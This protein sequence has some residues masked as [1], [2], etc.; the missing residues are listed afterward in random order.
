MDLKNPNKLQIV[1]DNEW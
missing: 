1:R